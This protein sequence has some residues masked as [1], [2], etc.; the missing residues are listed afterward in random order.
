[1]KTRTILSILLVIA[2]LLSAC[3]TGDVKSTS[4]SEGT[5]SQTTTQ[6]RASEQTSAPT[7]APTPTPMP[8][9]M[10]ETVFI[11]REELP[12]GQ[13]FEEEY[14]AVLPGAEGYLVYDCFG[15][16]IYTKKYSGY[17]DEYIPIGLLEKEKIEDFIT[18]PDRDELAS[19]IYQRDFPGG[20][21]EY[22]IWS[23]ETMDTPPDN[24]LRVFSESGQ[25]LQVELDVEK[26]YTFGVV[27]F[28]ES[29][30]ICVEVLYSAGNGGDYYQK[31]YFVR[32]NA[33]GS[34]ASNLEIDDLTPGP[35]Q[36][37]GE[38]YAV[39]S[40]YDDE[41]KITWYLADLSGNILMEDVKSILLNMATSLTQ[42]MGSVFF[43]DYFMKD[44]QVYDARLKTV[45]DE[46]KS[47]DGHLIPGIK[48]YVDG[49][50]C[51]VL[52]GFEESGYSDF[53]V[54]YAE[55]RNESGALAIK[56]DWGE[57]VI[58]D[59]G[60]DVYVAGVNSSL[61][62]LSNYTIY[63]SKTGEFIAN[64]R[65]GN[66]SGPRFEIADEYLLLFYDFGFSIIDND[67]NLRYVSDSGNPMTISGEYFLL[68]KDS[69]CALMDLN[70]E[71]VLEP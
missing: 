45:S 17:E 55:S 42:G 2:L 71:V 7:E 5:A 49:I 13:L 36:I 3:G 27:P 64:T 68:W 23:E 48:Y 9:P 26:T 4:T 62:V 25:E 34:V 29:T 18:I 35:I 46:T 39:F 61:L 57:F 19:G 20:H 11:P 66:A 63:S 37:V 54:S 1:M 6:T 22:Y 44:G 51:E 53:G 69:G 40:E 15:K 31:I 24:Y 8:T 21:V 59:V 16:T 56:S 70:G 28:E 38:K 50:A 41:G 10:T 65:F 58:R 52:D 12:D 32:I 30:G 60:D 14:Y 67:G 47:P 33:D 43:Y